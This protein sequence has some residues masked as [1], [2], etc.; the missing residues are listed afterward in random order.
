MQLFLLG[1]GMGVVGGLLPTPL[2]L[3]ATTQMTL[4][5]RARA[6]WVLVG[7]PTAIDA[8]FLLITYF[9]YKMIPPF[10]AHDMA[11]VGGAALA[12]FGAYL[13]WANPRK[14]PE[15]KEYAWNLT[16]GS[17][18][19]ATLVEASAPGTWVYWLTVAGPII[20]EG[21]LEGYGRIVPFFVAS[22][23]GYYAASF[24]SVWLMAW[25]AGAH[26]R[27]RK[28]MFLAANLLLIV[29]GALFIARAYFV[30]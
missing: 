12:G 2:H 28:G 8:V 1:L 15:K 10:I 3:I 25:G 7:P 18:A 30:G 17:L 9:F 11:Y 14:G 5:R 22:L 13:L 26:Q 27:F 6:A 21:R 19:L 24:L 29:L 4:R 23:L 20:A 16:S